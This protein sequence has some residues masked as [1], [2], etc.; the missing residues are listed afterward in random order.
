MRI[1]LLQCDH[2]PAG[3]AAAGGGD[4]PQ[5]FQA[6]FPDLELRTYDLTRHEFPARVD[7]CAGYLTTGSHYSVYDDI[8]WIKRLAEFTHRVRLARLPLV[9]ICFG[10]QMLAHALGGRVERAER[11]W[12]VGIHQMSVIAPQ[13]WMQPVHPAPGLFM[14]CQDQIV[15]LPEGS[16]ILATGDTVTVSMQL[17]DGHMLGV[18]G[19][20]E[21]SADYARAIYEL[22]RTRVGDERIEAALAT[23]DSP[24]DGPLVARWITQF[25]AAWA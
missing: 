7:E 9:G 23:M 8:D 12:G 21:F 14:S 3:L 18:G 20:P 10:H 19:H 1:G 15:A 24:D 25:F 13:P 5:R 11:G 17:L 16:R 6:R 4:Y 22:R 2:V